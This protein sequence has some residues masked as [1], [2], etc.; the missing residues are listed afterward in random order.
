MYH[1]F[2]L[3]LCSILFLLTLFLLPTSGHVAAVLVVGGPEDRDGVLLPCGLLLENVAHRH[4]VALCVGWEGN[5]VSKSWEKH[6]STSPPALVFNFQT[7]KKNQKRTFILLSF[8]ALVSQSLL[9][10]PGFRGRRWRRIGGHLPGVFALSIFS[11]PPTSLVFYCAEVC[12]VASL[13]DF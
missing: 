10:G 1:N 13:P 7:N 6:F 5:A 3:H 11:S 12:K 9:R 2:T 8:R 4:S